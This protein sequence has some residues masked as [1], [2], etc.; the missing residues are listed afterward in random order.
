MRL[1]DIVTDFRWRIG[2][3]LIQGYLSVASC[4]IDS[5]SYDCDVFEPPATAM[6]GESC[7]AFDQSVIDKITK[8][9]G[10]ELGSLDCDVFEPPATA[11]SG[12]SC[13]AFDQSVIDKI[14]KEVGQEL[15]SLASNREG[16]KKEMFDIIVKFRDNDRNGSRKLAQLKT[17]FVSTFLNLSDDCN[18]PK[19][20]KKCAK[21]WSCIT[22]AICENVQIESFSLSHLE[23][24]KALHDAYV[25]SQNC[26]EGAEE[27][28]KLYPRDES[29]Q[30]LV[31]MPTDIQKSKRLP[32]FDR[33]NNS[34]RKSERQLQRSIVEPV[35]VATP[36]E[37]SSSKS[38]QK[39]YVKIINVDSC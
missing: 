31:Q 1:Q 25:L 24:M 18:C 4:E 33:G 39:N 27:S 3:D 8:E 15:G 32:T 6:S 38:K 2:A 36:Q 12:E 16:I 7:D 17:V 30:L 19:L 22:Y 10:Q 5:V 21:L 28:F 9:V 23:R 37:K 34:V 13:D 26:H 20:K 35:H 11:M 14:T 29:Q